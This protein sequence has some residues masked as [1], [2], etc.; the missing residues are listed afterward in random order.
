MNIKKFQIILI[1]SLEDDNMQ[2]EK[3][4]N[5]VILKLNGKTIGI[6]PIEKYTEQL[7]N[8]WRKVCANRLK[9]PS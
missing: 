1:A 7:A 2:V 6:I 5:L 4:R 9:K 3:H 8:H